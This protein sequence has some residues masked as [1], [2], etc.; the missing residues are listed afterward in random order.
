MKLDIINERDIIEGIVASIL[1]PLS[2]IFYRHF[3]KKSY[4]IYTMMLAWFTVWVARKLS[5]NIWLYHKEKYNLENYTVSI[6]I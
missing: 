5:V 4:F 6:N 1:Y 2:I 3:D